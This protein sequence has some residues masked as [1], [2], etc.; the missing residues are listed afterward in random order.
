MKKILLTI[1]IL[2]L[3]SGSIFAAGEDKSLDPNKIFYSANELY[4]KREYVK[5]LEE[6]KKILDS[7]IDSGGLYYNMGNSYFKLNKLGYAVLFYEKAKRIMPYDSDL[8][9]N[10]DYA[11][12]LIT[13]SATDIPKKN[14]VVSAI[15]A[16]FK[17]FS[18]NAIA[19]CGLCVFLIFVIL[20]GLAII[21]PVAL[22]KIRIVYAAVLVFFMIT[23]G[24][25]AIRYYDEE[26]LRRGVVVQKE[27]E[28]RYEPIDKST[29]FYK[30]REGEEVSIMKTRDG[31]RQI[32]R[33]DGK[34][35]WVPQNAV[36][37]I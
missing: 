36:E 10:L 14:V 8:K 6:Y 2:L 4:E 29:M 34:A 9:A 26:V 22:K 23:V 24:A 1:G 13:V 15:K 7:G 16:P 3:L 27:I 21:N 31:W 33:I 17:D 32:K 35:G 5:A 30:L 37:E 19:T 18:L 25:F 28:C 20:Q 12:S 11:K